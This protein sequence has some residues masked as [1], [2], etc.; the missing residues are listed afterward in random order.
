LLDSTPKAECT[1]CVDE[2]VA[3]LPFDLL[4]VKALQQLLLHGGTEDIITV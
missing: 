1:H 2:D 3:R 4:L